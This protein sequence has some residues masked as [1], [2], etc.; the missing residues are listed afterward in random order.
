MSTSAFLDRRREKDVMALSMC[1]VT[2]PISQYLKFYT[3]KQAQIYPKNI[4]SQVTSKHVAN[5][6]SAF[7]RN[8]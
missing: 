1:E 2:F 7:I 6:L 8:A 5:F 3:T 4:K